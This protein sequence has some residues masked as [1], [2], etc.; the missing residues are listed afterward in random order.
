V[1]SKNFPHLPI[2]LQPLRPLNSLL[3]PLSRSQNQAINPEIINLGEFE[4]YRVELGDDG[5][6]DEE[7]GRARE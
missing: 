7:A 5:G 6:V 1:A 4:E 2:F 3:S